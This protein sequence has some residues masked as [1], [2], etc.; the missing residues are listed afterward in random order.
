M[1]KFTIIVTL[2]LPM[3]FQLIFGNKANEGSI[4]LSFWKVSLISL[5]GQVLSTIWNFF[6]VNE[7]VSLSASR[8]GWPVIG[9]LTIELIVG[10]FLVL[11]ILIQRY[12]QYRKNKL[13][14]E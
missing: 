12:I 14:K 6:L 3:I 1:I 2:F 9:I 13:L 10:L 7:L 11:M 5:F 4:S 8:N